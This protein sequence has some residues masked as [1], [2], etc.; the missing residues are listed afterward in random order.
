MDEIKL[1]GVIINNDLSG[2]A[3]QEK[4]SVTAWPECGSSGTVRN[5]EPVKSRCWKYTQHK[6]G[7]LLKWLSL[8]ETLD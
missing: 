3:L 5:M 2:K 1:L 4:L 8:Y 6:S 7:A